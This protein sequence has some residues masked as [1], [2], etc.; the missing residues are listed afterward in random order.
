MNQTQ[1]VKPAKL[2][3]MD[4]EAAKQ[5]LTDI[6][7]KQGQGPDYE[8]LMTPT[9]GKRFILGQTTGSNL[10]LPDS[11]QNFKPKHLKRD[12]PKMQSTNE[13]KMHQILKA[14][15]SKGKLKF[16]MEASR[17]MTN[18]S[19]MVKSDIDVQIAEMQA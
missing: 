12:L 11:K 5:K 14:A 18:F 4:H 16:K 10:Q 3:K 1:R 13:H 2:E 17:T 6:H 8:Q 15:K 9:G 7:H 19:S